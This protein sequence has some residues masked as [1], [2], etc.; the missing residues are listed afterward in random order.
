[1]YERVFPV[2]RLN[3]KFSTSAMF[4]VLS[5]FFASYVSIQQMQFLTV[6][7]R[8]VLNEQRCFGYYLIFLFFC[9][10]SLYILR[11]TC[12]RHVLCQFTMT[13]FKCL[14]AVGDFT[15]SGGGPSLAPMPF[16]ISGLL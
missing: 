5:F 13:D 16:F 7:T 11:K 6:P 10:L 8:L 4:C 2:C 15:R 3:D 9:I 1:M 14:M 12:I